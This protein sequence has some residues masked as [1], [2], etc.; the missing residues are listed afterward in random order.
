MNSGNKGS[1]GNVFNAWA[2]VTIGGGAITS[3]VGMGALLTYTNVGIYTFTLTG[4][5]AM[6]ARRWSCVVGPYDAA[7]SPTWRETDNVNN[8]AKVFTFIDNTGAAIDLTSLTIGA[9]F[10]PV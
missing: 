8:V 6:S 9:I 10:L 4:A 3:Q 1:A 2:S 7:S 5:L